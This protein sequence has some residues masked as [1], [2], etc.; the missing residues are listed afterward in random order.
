MFPYLFID[1]LPIRLPP[2]REHRKVV[3][4]DMISSDDTHEQSQDE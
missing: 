1:H 3:Q 4:D 2:P